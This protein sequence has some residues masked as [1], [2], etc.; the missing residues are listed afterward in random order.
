MSE[1]QIIYPQN[2]YEDQGLNIF[3]HTRTD[4]L[5]ADLRKKASIVHDVNPLV[6]FA[7]LRFARRVIPNL[8][9]VHP[10]N[11]TAINKHT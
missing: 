10:T 3:S 5:P 9:R 7:S 6:D 8:L 11:Q 2:T 1:N 4:S